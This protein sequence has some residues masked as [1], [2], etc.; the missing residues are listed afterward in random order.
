MN[1]I[2]EHIADLINIAT[3]IIASAS[4]ITALTPSNSDDVSAAEKM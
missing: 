2:V 3:L 4:A 1:W